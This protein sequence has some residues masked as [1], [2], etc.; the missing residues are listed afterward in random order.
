MNK[1][2]KKVS[3]SKQKLINLGYI[4]VLFNPVPAGIIFGFIL[5]K[6]KATNKDGNLMM[7]LS[8]IWG[9][10]NLILTQRLLGL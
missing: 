5:K 8:G 3:F 1:K 7:I 6:N 10:I 9:V 4:I 2:S